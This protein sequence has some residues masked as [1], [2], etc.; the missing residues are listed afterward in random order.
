MDNI[1]ISAYKTRILGINET[2][3]TLQSP[4]DR[5]IVDTPLDQ[6]VENLVRCN[7]FMIH[8]KQ[9]NEDSNNLIGEISFLLK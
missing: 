8:E 9:R 2:P 5:E 1:R 6:A 4:W 7:A 3:T